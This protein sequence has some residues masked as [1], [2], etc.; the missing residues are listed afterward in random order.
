MSRFRS[1]LSPKFL[2]VTVLYVGVAFIMSMLCRDSAVKAAL[3]VI[4]LLALVPVVL[5]FGRMASLVV[6]IVA[7][8]IFATF[9]FEP[10]GTLAISS[11]VDRIELLCFGLAAMAIV[12]FSPQ[13]EGLTKTASAMKTLASLENWIA[14][15]GYVVVFT[16][17]VTLLLYM[18]N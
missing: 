12:H 15:V 16:A 7:S 1:L 18:W 14:I 17:I 5:I 10:Y 4:F 9:L 13:P 11:A 6:A 8:F 3:P 2:I